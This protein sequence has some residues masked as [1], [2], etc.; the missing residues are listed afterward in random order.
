PEHL[1]KSGLFA[2]VSLI[3]SEHKNVPVILK[4]AV[5][6]KEP[7]LYVFLIENNKAFLREVKL[8]LRQGQYYEVLE[9]VKEGDLV[10]IMGQQ[11]LFEG[12]EVTIEE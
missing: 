3:I 4:E 5:L 12:A 11:K 8:G 1:L 7:N 2:K 10:V 9:G 6:G